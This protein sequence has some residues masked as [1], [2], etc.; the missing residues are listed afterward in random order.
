VGVWYLIPPIF[1]IE[2]LVGYGASPGAPRARP[3]PRA[4]IQDPYFSP[5]DRCSE[6]VIS[7]IS[8]AENSLNLA[9]YSFTH[10]DIAEALMEAHSRGM[11][12]RVI[13]EG[14]Q[15]G[16]YSHVRWWRIPPWP[17]PS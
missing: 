17:G 6:V 3:L 12:V 11:A 10:R 2:V 8:K 16:E 15:A 9:I 1:L 5:E 7:W 13:L 4:A 14:E